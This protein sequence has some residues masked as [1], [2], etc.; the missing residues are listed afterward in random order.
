M[1][2]FVAAGPLT[3][4]TNVWDAR[5]GGSGGLVPN[6]IYWLSSTTRGHMTTVRPTTGQIVQIGVAFSKTTLNVQITPLIEDHDLTDGLT[7]IGNGSEF[8]LTELG[9]GPLSAAAYGF[10]SGHDFEGRSSASWQVEPAGILPG[11]PIFKLLGEVEPGQAPASAA[12]WLSSH[13]I[14]LKPPPPPTIPLPSISTSPLFVSGGLFELTEAQWNAVWTATDPDRGAG[15]GL[16][17]GYPYYLSDVPGTFFLIDKTGT[18]PVAS[19]NWITKCF[20]A[21]SS[22]YALIQI[23]DPRSN[24]PPSPPAPANFVTD[25]SDVVVLANNTPNQNVLTCPAITAAIGSTLVVDAALNYQCLNNTILEGLVIVVLKADG[26]TIAT[27][28]QAVSPDDQGD[29]QFDKHAAI[30]V[31]WNVDVIDTDPHV[32]SIDVTTDASSDGGQSIQS[33][34]MAVNALQ[35]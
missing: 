3:L 29:P 18:P 9:G 23:G 33:A 10:G 30:A 1:A 7:I 6:A 26:F 34:S 35:P 17:P 28:E 31:H 19:G 21:L 25:Q 13:V 16:L 24:T 14:G 2:R 5:T 11:T 27:F 15:S 32:Y 22:T 20:V 12:A 8:S 4:S